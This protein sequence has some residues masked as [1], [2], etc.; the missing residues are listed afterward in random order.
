MPHWIDL[1]VFKCAKKFNFAVC[2]FIVLT[3]KEIHMTGASTNP[4]KLTLKKTWELKLY[5][6]IENWNYILELKIEITYWNWKLKLYF[7]IENWSWKLKSKLK[8]Q[9]WNSTLKLKIEIENWN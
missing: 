2:L 6:E 8:I 3:K 1:V 7:E 9:N 5:I 4:K